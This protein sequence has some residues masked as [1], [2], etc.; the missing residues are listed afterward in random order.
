MQDDD[1]EKSSQPN[2]GR[3]PGVGSFGNDVPEAKRRARCMDPLVEA[4]SGHMAIIIRLFG[5]FINN[6]NRYWGPNNET[7]DKEVVKQWREDWVEGNRSTSCT[8]APKFLPADQFFRPVSIT[9]EQW[10][11]HW[12]ESRDGFKSEDLPHTYHH[13]TIKEYV[14]MKGIIHLMGLFCLELYPNLLDM[15][16]TDDLRK[17]LKV[18]KDD[19]IQTYKS[20]ELRAARNSALNKMFEVFNIVTGTSLNVDTYSFF[21]SNIEGMKGGKLIPFDWMCTAMGDKATSKDSLLMNYHGMHFSPILRTQWEN[22]NRLNS[23]GLTVQTRIPLADGE[24]TIPPNYGETQKKKKKKNK[25]AAAETPNPQRG[26][27]SQSA[28]VFRP[29]L[30]ERRKAGERSGQ[31]GPPA[32]LRATPSLH[33]DPPTKERGRVTRASERGKGISGGRRADVPL[34]YTDNRRCFCSGIRG[35]PIVLIISG[36]NLWVSLDLFLKFW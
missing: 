21:Q 8:H 7:G 19:A 14:E 26:D 29:S 31:P 9:L 5:N 22:Y 2:E 36:L 32:R 27:G 17:D 13:T 3:D 34:F 10:K 6:L 24:A 30:A 1:N 25:F 16:G 11:E 12:G 33:P 4:T 35:P 15:F 28:R 23:Q 20:P 18:L